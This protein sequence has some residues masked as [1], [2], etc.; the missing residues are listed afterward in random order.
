MCLSG[1]PDW[2]ALTVSLREIDFAWVKGFRGRGR[3]ASLVLRSTCGSVV[4]IRR[5]RPP[6]HGGRH[7]RNGELSGNDRLN[8]DE[9]VRQIR[10]G[11][12]DPSEAV[13]NRHGVEL[14]PPMTPHDRE[15]LITAAQA[16]SLSLFDTAY[17]RLVLALGA[18]HASRDLGLLAAAQR[19]GVTVRD[20]TL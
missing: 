8:F 1:A 14:A 17:L 12:V 16:G 5:W 4:Q 11:A 9:D 18:E 6:H 15:A 2:T 20:L 19:Y 7:R 13:R 10:L 3:G